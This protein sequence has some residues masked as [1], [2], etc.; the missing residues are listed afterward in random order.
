[1]KDAPTRAQLSALQQMLDEAGLNH[2]RA[3]PASG[4]GEHT[5]RA[6]RQGTQIRQVI[7][8]D[9]EQLVQLALDDEQ[10]IN[11]KTTAVQDGLSAA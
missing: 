11:P 1:M 8:E 6:E 7:H 5:F 4:Y 3:M 9:P 2:W 10:R